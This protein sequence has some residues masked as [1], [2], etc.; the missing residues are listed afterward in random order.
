MAVKLTPSSTKPETNQKRISSFIRWIT[1][2]RWMQRRD[3]GLMWHINHRQTGWSIG[4]STDLKRIVRYILWI[5]GARQN[6]TV[7]FLAAGEGSNQF[8]P[9]IT[10]SRSDDFLLETLIGVP[11]V[12]VAKL[13]FGLNDFRYLRL[14]MTCFETLRKARSS[15]S[16]SS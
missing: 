14:R 12:R 6:A 5:T 2:H 13:V 4:L 16:M 3:Y 15:T 9:E 11:S 8:F 1:L 7:V 10:S